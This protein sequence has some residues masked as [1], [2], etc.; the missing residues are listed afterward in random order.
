MWKISLPKW[1]YKV[2]DESIWASKANKNIP[3]ANFIV[4]FP[5]RHWLGPHWCMIPCHENVSLP[6]KWWKWSQEVNYPNIKYLHFKDRLHR[7]LISHEKFEYSLNGE[8]LVRKWFA[9]L[10]RLSHKNSTLEYFHLYFLVLPN[11]LCIQ[12]NATY[13]KNFIAHHWV[14]IV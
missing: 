6:L 10:K 12:M 1:K 4:I 3:Y 9:F 8:R 7:H 5:H 11:A 14:H 2:L 13:S